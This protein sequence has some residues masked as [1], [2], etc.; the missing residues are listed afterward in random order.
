[1]YIGGRFAYMTTSPTDLFAVVHGL[2]LFFTCGRAQA[3]PA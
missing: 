2:F 3:L 1:M